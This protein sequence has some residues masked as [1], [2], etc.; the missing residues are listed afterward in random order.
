MAE[1]EF[2]HTL[3]DVLASFAQA[4]RYTV[5]AM[6]RKEIASFAY[7]IKRGRLQIVLVTNRDKTRWIL[8]KGQPEPHMRDTEVALM[9]AY[10]EGGVLGSLDT[11]V[12]CRRVALNTARGRVKLH[13]YAMRITK[14]LDDWPE[15]DFRK[16]KVLEPETALKKVDKLPL[17]KCIQVL[18]RQIKR[19]HA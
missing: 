9:E 10:E 18:A 16:R 6:S 15:A 8:P 2:Q 17:R 12:A 14:L 5:V 4:A 1:C 3:F 7:V 19:M 11:R 13:V